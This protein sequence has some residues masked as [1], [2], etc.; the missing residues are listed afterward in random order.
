MTPFFYENEIVVKKI[1]PGNA[2]RISS[3][4]KF[5]KFHCFKWIFPTR[6]LSKLQD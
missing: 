3:G 2:K 5:G 6:K 4:R 1:G